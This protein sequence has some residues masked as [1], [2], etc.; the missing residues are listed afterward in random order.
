LLTAAFWVLTLL[1]AYAFVGLLLWWSALGY[2]AAASVLTYLWWKRRRRSRFAI[3]FGAVCALWAGMAWALSGWALLV[4]TSIPVDS[5]GARWVD[6]GSVVSPVPADELTVTSDA[7]DEE[8][9]QSRPVPPSW[10]EE[11]CAETLVDRG[12]RAAGV[13]L[14]GVFAAARVVGHVV[15]PA[16]PRAAAAGTIE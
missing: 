11:K 16:G 3:A 14:I 15:S 2:L 8:V 9:T 5:V 6:C 4:P 1:F 7:S 13:A 12:S 10:M